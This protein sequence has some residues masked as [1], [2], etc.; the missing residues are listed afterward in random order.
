M[1]RYEVRDK[2]NLELLDRKMSELGLYY[3]CGYREDYNELHGWSRR[4]NEKHF[5]TIKKLVIDV[6]LS[7]LEYNK[8]LYGIDLEGLMSDYL[9]YLEKESEISE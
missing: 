3:E 7:P 2:I 8:E 5:I 4:E 9:L 1:F 6:D